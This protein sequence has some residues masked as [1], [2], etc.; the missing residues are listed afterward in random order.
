MKPAKTDKI[1][2]LRTVSPFSTAHAFC[3]SWEGQRNSG[4]LKTVATKTN[5]FARFVEM[6]EKEV[7]VR[8]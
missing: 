5:I 4:F 3:S 8:V 6:R 7:L 2:M 1:P